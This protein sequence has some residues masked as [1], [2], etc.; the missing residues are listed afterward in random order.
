MSSPDVTNETS[1]DYKRELKN[2]EVL[3][4]F[5]IATELPGLYDYIYKVFPELYNAAGGSYGRIIA[6]KALNAKRKNKKTPF[7]EIDVE[8]VS[9][10]GFIVPLVYGLQELMEKRVVN[11]Y[12]Q[13]V[14]SQGPRVFLEKNL[15]KIVAHYVGIFSMCDY[16]PQK[17]GKNP[18]SYVQALAGFKMAIAG[19]L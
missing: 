18:Q 5:R 10:E 12:S 14:W 8:T 6:V 16:D 4:A 11:N 9:P 17:I 3:S 13:I 15:K 2:Q 1:H 7:T 19:I